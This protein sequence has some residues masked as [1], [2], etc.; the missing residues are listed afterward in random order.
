MFLYKNMSW[1]I[2]TGLAFSHCLLAEDTEALQP[3]MKA[4]D[5]DWAYFESIPCKDIDK[6]VYHSPLEESLLAKR[7]GQCMDQYKAFYTRPATR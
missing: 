7:K 4:V 2:L 1:L 3:S 5:R 6:V